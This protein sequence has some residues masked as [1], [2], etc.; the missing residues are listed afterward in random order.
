MALVNYNGAQHA[1]WQPPL[2][3]VKHFVATKGDYGPSDIT[4][5]SSDKV[6]YHLHR[7]HLARR[8]A[9]FGDASDFSQLS[10]VC[11]LAEPADVL[12]VLF[13]CV[14]DSSPGAVDPR[15]FLYGQGVVGDITSVS[16]T[17]S[18]A[19]LEAAVKYQMDG[20]L[21][22]GLALGLAC[23]FVRSWLV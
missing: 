8:S 20:G 19:V 12:D 4:V 17:I 13:K 10:G 14:D 5:L 18:F 7:D 9:V 3:G 1:V 22:S 16:P 2:A 11:A 6:V 15:R 23:V 21:L